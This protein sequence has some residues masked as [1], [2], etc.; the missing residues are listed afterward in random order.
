VKTLERWYLAV[1]LGVV[2]IA[3]GLWLAG[4]QPR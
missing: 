3:A 1:V 4:L 2:L